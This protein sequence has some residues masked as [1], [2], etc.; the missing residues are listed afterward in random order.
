LFKKIK[1]VLIDQLKVGVSSEKLTQ[2]LLAGI[3]IGISPLIGLTTFI[4]IFI[5][6]IFKLNQ[7]VL[8]TANYAM[9]PIQILM[10]P[11]YIKS[12]SYFFKVNDFPIRP[13]LI[14]EKFKSGPVLYFKT[15]GPIILYSIL[16]WIIVSI[17]LYFILKP[18]ILKLTSK[19]KNSEL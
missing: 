19:L 9:Y 5:G 3:I 13:D 18:L 10:I 12:V 17:V 14:W 16:I 2:A 8:Q 7:V 4:S 1:N 15:F 11:V 6:Y